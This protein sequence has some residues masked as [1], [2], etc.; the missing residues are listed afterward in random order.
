MRVTPPLCAQDTVISRPAAPSPPTF[1]NAGGDEGD[2]EELFDAGELLHA[3]C[4]GRGSR[5]SSRRAKKAAAR[6]E[7]ITS[8]LVFAKSRSHRAVV[9]THQSII[10]P[11]SGWASFAAPGTDHSRSRS[12]MRVS[13]SKS[14]APRRLRITSSSTQSESLC[15]DA[16]NNGS[17]AAR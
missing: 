12:R 17:L 13:N 2:E 15:W 11:K 1:G 16:M 5:P 3:S 7:V 10:E 9:T 14:T 4:R 8:R 6:A